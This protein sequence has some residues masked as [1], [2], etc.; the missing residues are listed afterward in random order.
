MDRFKSVKNRVLYNENRRRK[1][2]AV[3]IMKEEN[4]KNE[5]SHTITEKNDDSISFTVSIQLDGGDDQLLLQKDVIDAKLNG[6]K[7]SLYIKRNI[8]QRKED[9]ENG[10]LV[11]KIIKQETSADAF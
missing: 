1:R 6:I 10:D 5:D 4:M 3:K 11:R 9:V 7:I 8:F 2:A